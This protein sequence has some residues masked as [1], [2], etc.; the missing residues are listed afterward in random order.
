MIHNNHILSE[1]FQTG[2]YLQKNQGFILNETLTKS[3]K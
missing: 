2:D 1:L 3:L